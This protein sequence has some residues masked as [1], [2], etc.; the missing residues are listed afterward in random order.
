MSADWTMG[1]S[2]EADPRLLHQAFDRS[3]LTLVCTGASGSIDWELYDG[4]HPLIQAPGA[5]GESLQYR[6]SSGGVANGDSVGPPLAPGQVALVGALS[7]GG[8]PQGSIGFITARCSP[9]VVAADCLYDDGSRTRLDAIASGSTGQHWIVW[10]LDRAEC[11]VRMDFLAS[12]GEVLDSQP[13]KD[14][15]GF[16]NPPHMR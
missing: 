13:I 3:L 10:H 6:L 1:G 7:A 11:A 5:V 15:R 12:D 16:T 8:V 2:R 4:P 9:V 14:P